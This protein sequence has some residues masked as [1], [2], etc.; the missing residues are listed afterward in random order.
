MLLFAGCGSGQVAWTRVLDLGG[1]DVA[2]ALDGNGSELVLL[3]TSFT[4]ERAAWQVARFA[5]DG[6]ELWRR[7]YRQG[8]FSVAGDIALDSAGGI[9]ATGTSRIDGREM[10][11]VVHYRRDGIIA[12]QRALAVGEAA[13][14]RGIALG[15][16]RVYVTGWTRAKDRRELLLVALEPDG[17]TAWTRNWRLGDLAAGER[18]ALD[19]KGDIVLSGI[20]G[21]AENP[22]ILLAKFNPKGDT[23]WTRVYDGGGED[24]PGRVTTDPYGHLLATGTALTPEGP[25]CVILEYH[26]DGELIR[27]AAY[28]ERATAEGHG[29]AVT[30][31]GDVFLCG[32]L[33]AETERSLLAFHY[34]PQA[35]SV[36]ERSWRTGADVAGADLVVADD[37][38]ALGTVGDRDRGRDVALVRFTR[39]EAE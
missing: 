23:L 7:Q 17:S 18:L 14:G 34:R 37:V 22:D 30:P 36:W 39:P 35:T 6:R 11:V 21:T 32:S 28:G 8:E 10:C 15:P 16:D 24:R 1:D 9:Y 25:R 27:R 4:G 31:K 33:V 20:A 3:A 26:P 29:I 12:W 5:T 2:A 19:P 13:A 38:F